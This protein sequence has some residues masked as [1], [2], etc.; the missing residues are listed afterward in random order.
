MDLKHQEDQGG[1]GEATA[2]LAD[3]IRRWEQKAPEPWKRCYPRHYEVGQQYVSPK[4]LGLKLLEL[5]MKAELSHRHSEA[6][7]SQN[8][9]MMFAAAGL[10]NLQVPIFFVAPDL[11]TAV[12]LSIPAVDLDWRTLPLPFTSAAFAL[13]RGSLKHDTRGEVSYIWYTR[14]R[15]GEAYI[16]FRLHR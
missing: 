11:L 15:K 6:Q 7:Q 10:V 2:P 12:R 8:M 1:R 3:A 4:Q 13:P 5:R 16:V 9:L 14:I